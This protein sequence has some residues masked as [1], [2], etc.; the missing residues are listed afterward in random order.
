VAATLEKA[1]T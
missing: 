1:N